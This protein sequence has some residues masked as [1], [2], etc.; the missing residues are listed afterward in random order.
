MQATRIRVVQTVTGGDR[1]RSRLVGEETSIS[2]AQRPRPS[3][4][5]ADVHGQLI[6]AGREIHRGAQL[7]AAVTDCT[8]SDRNSEWT[9]PGGAKCPRAVA[10]PRLNRTEAGG[11]STEVAALR[12]AQGR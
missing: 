7:A 10:G 2:A 1:R 11:N 5:A 12:R 4:W 8:G 6:A 3:H 9:A